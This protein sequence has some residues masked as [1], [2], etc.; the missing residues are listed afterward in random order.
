MKNVYLAMANTV[1]NF[2]EGAEAHIS[3]IGVFDTE[4]KARQAVTDYS[5]HHVAEEHKDVQDELAG[6][7]AE[8]AQIGTIELNK[9]YPDLEL[10][11][12][13]Y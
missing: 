11:Y 10:D 2:S 5:R 7:I 1:I 13:V 3:L 4:E 9:M 6:N 8:I 12:E